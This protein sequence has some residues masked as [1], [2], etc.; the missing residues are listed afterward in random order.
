MLRH[1]DAI[2][3]DQWMTLLM[4]EDLNYCKG[5]RPMFG[6]RPISLVESTNAII[7]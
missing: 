1:T 4:D 5:D 6:Y 7:L 2:A 3:D